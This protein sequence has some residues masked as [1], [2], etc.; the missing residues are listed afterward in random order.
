MAVRIPALE[1]EQELNP[2]TSQS[3]GMLSAHRVE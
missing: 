3:F 2:D 1:L